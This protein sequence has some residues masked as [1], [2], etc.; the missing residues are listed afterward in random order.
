MIAI[1][2]I[3]AAVMLIAA[4]RPK[5]TAVEYEVEADEVREGVRNGWYTCV[6]T[7]QDGQPVVVLSGKMTDGKDY[8]GV[9]TISPDDWK[10]LKNE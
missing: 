1:G 2:V 5:D 6:L 8:T 3:V 4:T 9:F 7:I 10:A